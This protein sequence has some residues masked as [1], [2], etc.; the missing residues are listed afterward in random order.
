M[1]D[2]KEMCTSDRH[3]GEGQAVVR[4]RGQVMDKWVTRTSY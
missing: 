1:H 3:A 4:V 2:G